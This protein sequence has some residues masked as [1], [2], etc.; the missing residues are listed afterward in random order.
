MKL[1]FRYGLRAAANPILSLAGLS[2][3]A[4]LSVSLIVEIVSPGSKRTDHIAKRSEYADAGIPHYWIVD[5]G[6]PVSL[7]ACHL[8]G[9]LGY[10]DTGDVT[11]MFTTAAPFDI[12]V[13]LD[14]LL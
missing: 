4:L 5:I 7:V 6:E 11:G 3:A 8:A 12:R 2:V 13:N 1:L 10:Q 14:Q 9:E